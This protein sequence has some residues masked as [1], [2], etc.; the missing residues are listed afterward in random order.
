MQEVQGVIKGQYDYAKLRGGTGPLV[1]PAGFV[2]IF[3]IFWYICDRGANIAKAQWIFYGIYLLTLAIVMKIY[4][5][6]KLAPGWSLVLLCISKRI[7]AIYMLRMFNDGV[8]MLFLFAAVH[9]FCSSLAVSVKMNILLFA[10]PLLYLLLCA[11]GVYGAIRHIGICALVQARPSL[12]E[13]MTSSDCRTQYPTSYISGSFNF[14]RVF[15]HRWTVN[16][17]FVPEEIFVSKSFA[18]FL[19]FCHLSTLAVFYFKHLSRAAKERVRLH[20]GTDDFPASFISIVLFTGN[21]IGIVFARSLHFQFY[22]WYF[23]TIPALLWKTQLDTGVKLGLYALVELSFNITERKGCF[24]I[25]VGPECG[26]S[27]PT[28]AMILSAVHLVLLLALY[29]TPPWKALRPRGNKEDEKEK[30]K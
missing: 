16:F 3:S 7:H 5:R 14:S 11:H 22:T 15:L 13:A 30:K 17:K 20:S 25:P 2:W 24:Q 29:F 26:S 10:P 12:F 28:G 9:F 23:H 8:A 1:Y 18:V 19:L 4:V 27:T 21:F 6:A